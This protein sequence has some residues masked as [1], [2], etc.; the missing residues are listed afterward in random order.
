MY[1][2][3]IVQAGGKGTR[4]KHLTANKPKALVPVGNKPIIFGLFDKY[5]DKKFI[6]IGDYLCDVLKKYLDAFSPVNFILVNANGQEGTLGGLQSALEF[7]PPDESFMLIWS[8]LILPDDFTMPNKLDNYIGLSRDFPCRW[9]YENGVMSEERSETAGIAGFFAFQNKALLSD[10]PKEGELV[11]WLSTAD[12]HFE[13]L[14]LH[15]TQEFGLVEEVDKFHAAN[16]QKCRPFNKITV[17]KDGHLLKEGITAQGLAL[18]EKEKNWYK[19]YK[20]LSE[21]AGQPELDGIPAIHSFEP[22][23]MEK[24]NGKNVYEYTHMYTHQK[25]AVLEQLVSC[26]KALHSLET[27]P[28]DY[29]SIKDAYV[30][31]TFDRINKIRDLVP[32]ADDKYI[33]IN[34][35]KCRNIFFFRD[36]LEKKFDSYRVSRFEFLHGDCTFSNMMLRETQNGDETQ[37]T[38]VL[39]DPRGYFGNT[40]YFGDPLYDWAKLYYSVSGN[41]DLFNLKKFTLNIDKSA[42]EVTLNIESSGWE[43]LEEYF[44]ELIKDEENT[45]YIKL[46]HA[47]IW[48]SLSTYA[49]ENYDSVCGAFYNGLYLLEQA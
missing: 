13:E 36:E 3:I 39:I 21:Q 28:T 7:V 31:K 37:Y 16:P 10:C 46:V 26:L 5:K 8:D 27:A 38:P 44:F 6:I 12:V 29:F 25:K 1:D 35:R 22:F 30:T 40:E 41:Y 47:V 4:M 23:I 42:K 48:L 11:R 17:T 19:K 43:D 18:A 20:T 34:G 2:Y 24:I 15:K 9:K 33:T 14:S 49:F 45:E 32:F